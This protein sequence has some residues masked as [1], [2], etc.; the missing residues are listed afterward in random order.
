MYLTLHSPLVM[1]LRVLPI[2]L[3]RVHPL[4]CPQMLQ[5]PL[6]CPQ[7]PQTSFIWRLLN[8]FTWCCMIF[9]STGHLLI[10]SCSQL[11]QTS[12]S[13]KFQLLTMFSSWPTSYY[14]HATILFCMLLTSSLMWISSTMV[15]A[16]L[17]TFSANWRHSHVDYLWLS[18]LCF[19]SL[20]SNAL[21]Q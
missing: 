21:A 9:H 15:Q 12:A 2:S 6:I 5:T 20:L 13:T 4:I 18:L 3:P 14:V 11:W 17:H 16:R 19:R 1:F 10:L 8:V 7:M